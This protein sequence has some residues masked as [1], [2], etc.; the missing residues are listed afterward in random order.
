MGVDYYKILGVPR[1]ASASAIKKAYHQLALKYHPD[2]NTD[3]REEAERK[4]KQVSEAYDVLS[5]EK[6]KKIYDQFGEEG[7]KGGMAEDGPG[8]SGGAGFKGFPGGR[9]GT[10]TFTNSD[11]F[12][13]FS[14]MFGSSDPYGGD[15]FGGGGPGFTR[16]FHTSGFGDGFGTPQQSP[17]GEAPSMEF[18][19]QCTLEEIFTGCTKKFKVTRNMP[20]GSSAK[21]F[22]V[23]VLPG[24]KKGTK[25][26]FDREGGMV[27]GYPPNA[28]ADLVFVLD[29][30]DHPRFKRNGADLTT[31]V[32]IPLKQ[33]LLGTD[34]SVK[35]IDGKDLTIPLKGVSKNGRK[36]RVAG[37]GMPDRK[38]KGR[39]DL[40]VVIEVDMPERISEADRKH[41]EQCT[42]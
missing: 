2:K 5:D 37:S 1:D 40:Y 13:I 6:K 35:G 21:E 9:G 17:P 12:N 8:G 22:E 29:E 33:A 30:K 18:A 7:L 41:V 3:N 4:F 20:S 10:Y 36:L 11:A 31:T 26:R 24:Y 23:N 38:T 34:I 39:G 27:D 14:K 42:F 16:M 25:I 32:H 19:F 28:L 15:M